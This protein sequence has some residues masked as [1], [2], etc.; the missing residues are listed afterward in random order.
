M[1]TL[2]KPAR[3]DLDPNPATAAKE[4]KHWH[5]TLNNFIDKCGENAPDKY[6]TLVNFVSHNDYEYI[7]DCTDYKVALS[8]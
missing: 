4:W 1:D 8:V 5:R 3:L 2:L 7:E 6:R